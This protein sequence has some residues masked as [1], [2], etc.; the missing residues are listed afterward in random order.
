MR[1]QVWPILENF[2][3]S[4]GALAALYI[5]RFEIWRWYDYKSSS[6]S[7]KSFLKTF[8]AQ[9]VNIWSFVILWMLLV[10]TFNF[11]H[12]Y[13][14]AYPQHI[15]SQVEMFLPAA[16]VVLAGIASSKFHMT[17]N[18]AHT[19]LVVFFTSITQMTIYFY[20]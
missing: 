5:F 4:L 15:L 12:Q 3:K 17:S 11:T 9:P 20:A 10:T 13:I 2:N 1:S 7:M 16:S 14:T 19:T 6:H 18:K 8:F